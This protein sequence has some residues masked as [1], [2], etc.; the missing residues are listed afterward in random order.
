M[1][2]FS[3]SAIKSFYSGLNVLLLGV[4]SAGFICWLILEIDGSNASDVRTVKLYCMGAFLVLVIPAVIIFFTKRFKINVR[5]ENGVL[6]IEVND[7]AFKG[8]LVIGEPYALVQQWL[9]EKLTE[10]PGTNK[11]YLTVCDVYGTPVVTFIADKTIFQK[12]PDEFI[13]IQL[14]A[15]SDDKLVCAPLNYKLRKMDGMIAVLQQRQ[16]QTLKGRS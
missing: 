8:P 16:S 15:E 9:Y 1:I 7:P 11:L 10:G 2:L 3:V 6:S 5:S 14:H 4:G 13:H 12:I